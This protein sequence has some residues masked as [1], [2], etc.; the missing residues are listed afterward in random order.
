MTERMALAEEVLALVGDRAEA[1]ARV[2]GGNL[3]LTRFANSFIHQN[4][5]EEGD[6]VSLRLAVDGRVVSGTTTNTNREA[7]S[8]FVDESLA[9]AA[10]QPVDEDWPGLSA[11]GPGTDI[12]HFDPMTADA[13]PATRAAMVA[14]FVAA[15]PG[16]RAAGYCSTQATEVAFAN[17]AGVRREGRYTQATL[18]GIHQTETSAGSGHATSVRVGDLDA[19]SVGD[20][21]AGRAQRG[22]DAYDIKPGEYE[23][24]LAPECVASIVVFLAFYGFNAKS[25]AEGQSFVELGEQQFDDRIELVDD[26][27]D[28]R[29]IALG[30][31]SEGTARRRL[32]LVGSGVSQSV[33]HDRRTAQ[34]AGVE[35]TGHAVPGGEVYGP[36]PTTMFLRGGATA[37]EHLIAGVDRGLYVATF[38]Y[39]RVLD[40]KTMAVTGLTRNGT[41]MIENGTITGAVTGMRFTQSFLAALGP[42]R[43][44]GLGDDARWADS[45]FG[46]GLVHAPSVRLAGWNFTGGTDA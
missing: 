35:S 44:L 38:N 16:M 36:F 46:A 43:V 4:V 17:S 10:L 25:Y 1:E 11:P 26:V 9:R 6:M 33:A 32:S 5:G 45:E 13:S 12:D 29:A 7:L 3:A 18:D 42:G 19:P 23:V 20:L 28:R 14:D 27:T 8:R 37:V 40:P 30:F 31:D 39:C 41:F 2:T 34:K 21:A 15:G 24:V 22:A